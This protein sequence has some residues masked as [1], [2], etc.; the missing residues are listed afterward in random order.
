M[1]QIVRCLDAGEG[2]WRL[3]GKDGD[4]GNEK[5]VTRTNVNF[6][7]R[8]WIIGWIRWVVARVTVDGGFDAATKQSAQIREV[9]PK[10]GLKAGSDRTKH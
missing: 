7:A 8:S 5:G 9:Q 4:E 10:R 3:V 6:E 1:F 2:L